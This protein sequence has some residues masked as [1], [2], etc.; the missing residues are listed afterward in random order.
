MPRELPEGT[1]IKEV[2]FDADC[3]GG[4]PNAAAQLRADSD[5]AHYDADGAYNTTWAQVPPDGGPPGKTLEM[6]GGLR[7]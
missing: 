3:S 5:P 7:A 4:D 2:T 6:D 1:R